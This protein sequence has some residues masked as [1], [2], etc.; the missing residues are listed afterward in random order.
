M[1]R[2]CTDQYRSMG[3]KNKNMVFLL[4]CLRYL[5]LRPLKDVL[6]CSNKSSAGFAY[7]LWQQHS[8]RWTSNTPNSN[9]MPGANI[10]IWINRPLQGTMWSH[11]LNMKLFKKLFATYRTGRKMA[12]RVWWFHCLREDKVWTW[13]TINSLVFQSC[14]HYLKQPRYWYLKSAWELPVRKLVFFHRKKFLDFHSRNPIIFLS[15]I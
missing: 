13:K 8:S 7:I 12:P 15:F 9:Q 1:I 4:P 5:F 10:T 11:R 14:L 3:W 2:G 6:V